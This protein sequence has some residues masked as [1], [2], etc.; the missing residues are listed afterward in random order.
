MQEK[1]VL[2]AQAIS[3]FASKKIS[4]GD[5]ILVYGWYGQHM[6]EKTGEGMVR[7][8]TAP[9]L[10]KQPGHQLV[11]LSSSISSS[12]LVSRILQEAWVEGKQFRVVVVDSRPRL[13]GRHMLRSLVRAWVQTYYLLIPAA[14]SVRPEVSV[15]TKK[16]LR[17]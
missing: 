3:R 7:A 1:I 13:E 12:S 17:G 15:L 5:V 4:N 9:S 6:A 10:C 14:S 11:T 16:E 2:A 8:M